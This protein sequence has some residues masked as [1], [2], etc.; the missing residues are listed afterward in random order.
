[1][2]AGATGFRI[3]GALE[4]GDY[5]EVLA[6]VLERELQSGRP[7]RLLV[8]IGPGFDEVKA[9]A[10]WEDVKRSFDFGVRHH[11]DWRRC[12]VVTDVAWIAR[13]SSAFGWMAPGELSVFAVA[14]LEAAKAWVAG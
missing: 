6:P 1:M 5:A 8:E 10:L 13:T 7:V 3:T 9:G 14:E 11:A 2:P 4:R 12:A